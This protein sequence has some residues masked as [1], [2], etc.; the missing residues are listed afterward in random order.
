MKPLLF[1]SLLL[2]PLIL[3]GSYLTDPVFASLWHDRYKEK[4]ITPHEGWSV[5]GCF[6][7]PPAANRNS[8][9]FGRNE[10]VFINSTYPL[11]WTWTNVA[12]NITWD[13]YLVNRRY[14]RRLIFRPIGSQA[15]MSGYLWEVEDVSN[16]PFFDSTGMFFFYVVRRDGFWAE[17]FASRFVNI[18]RKDMEALKMTSGAGVGEIGRWLG[19][20]LLAILSFLVIL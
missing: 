2:P 9:D 16:D 19:V 4:V 18:S 13:V 15:N 10:R 1:F 12:K 14:E 5:P 6:T 11:S 7:H 20:P 8:T 17:G 3:A